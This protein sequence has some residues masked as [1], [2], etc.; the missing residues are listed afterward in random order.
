M[1]KILRLLLLDAN[2]VIYLFEFSIWDKVVDRC[3]IFLARTVVKESIDFKDDAGLM[4]PI[5]LAP[6]EESEKITVVDVSASQAKAFRDSFDSL[7]VEQLHD[8]ETESLAWLTM[9]E[10]YLICSTDPVVFQ[11]LGN[12]GMRD[13]GIS[14]EEVLAKIG[15][16]KEL[17][18]LLTK[19]YREKWTNKGFEDKMY[20]FGR[21]CLS[22]S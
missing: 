18:H 12:L 21:K 10:G 15:L 1:A 20:G 11:V 13:Q 4:H 9:N 17:K 14:L 8:G 22:A 7:Y 19:N 3:E 6:Y 5:L 16:R 2:I